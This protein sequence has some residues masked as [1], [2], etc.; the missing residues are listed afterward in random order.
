MLRRLGNNILWET[1]Q[2]RS[3]NSC[4]EIEHAPRHLVLD[5]C[6]WLDVAYQ[7]LPC[8]FSKILEIGSVSDLLMWK[9]SGEALNGLECE[10]IRV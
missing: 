7:Y 4:C 9:G 10:M 6:D 8:S 5:G 3:S 1:T 2:D